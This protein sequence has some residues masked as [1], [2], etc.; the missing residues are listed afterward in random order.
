MKKSV[1]ILIGI[2][3]IMAIVTVSFFGLKIGEF[4]STTYVTNVEFTNSNIEKLKN[5][6]KIIYV[7]YSE[8][9]T[10]QLEWEVTPNDATHKEVNIIYDS[11]TT[12]GSVDQNGL[13][14]INSKGVLKITISSVDGSAKKDSL[15]LIII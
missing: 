13:V 2:I 15:K 12:V 5:G 8:N 6:D 10:F 1:I 14:T 9:A 11:A 7:T 3:Y 4:D